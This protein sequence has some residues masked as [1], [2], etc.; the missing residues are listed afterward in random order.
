MMIIDV[1]THIC[2]LPSIWFNYV[3]NSV[4]SWND[5]SSFVLEADIKGSDK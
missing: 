5:L 2:V 1:L 3:K 4:F